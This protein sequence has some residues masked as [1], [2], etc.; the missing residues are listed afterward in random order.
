MLT[1]RGM[2]AAAAAC[3]TVMVWG[4]GTAGAAPV[5]T[6]HSGWNWALPVPQGQTLSGVAFDGSTG[7]AVGDFGTVLRSTDGGQTWA[8][9]ASGTVANLD[10]VQELDPNTVIVGGGCALRESTDGGAT[11]R[12]VPINPSDS[13]CGSNVAGIAFSS[14]T[15][16]YVE[17]QSG[18]I[19]Y[20]TDGGATVQARTPVP[21]S[22]GGEATSLTF[23][24]PTTGFATTTN[25]TIEETTDGANSWTLVATTFAGLG[26]LTFVNPQ[27]A[28]AVGGANTVMKSTD[29]GA[30]WTRQTIS[31]PSPFL[32]AFNGITCTSTTQCLM[33]MTGSNSLVLT[34]DGGTTGSLVTPSSHQLNAV[35]FTTGAGVVGVGNNG[36]IVLSQDGG[37]QFPTLI[38][39]GPGLPT[40]AHVRSPLVAGAAPGSAYLLGT[41]GQIDATTDGGA[42]WRLEQTPSNA[43]VSAGAF[44][45]TTTG[46]VI[47]DD[48]I[49]RKTIDGGASWSSLDARVNAHTQLAAPSTS[50]VLLVGPR[51]IRRSA[52]GGRTFVKV[53]GH[54]RVG[55]HRRGPLVSA[56]ALQGALDRG[57]TV[58]AWAGRDAYE[59]T[60]AGRSWQ[61]IRL[62]R[63]TT[64]TDLSFISASSGYVLDKSGDVLFTHNRGQ[65]W[66]KL[67]DLGTTAVAGISF[68][69]A[70]RGLVAIGSTGTAVAPTPIDVLATTDGGRTWGPQVIDGV[71]HGLVLATAGPDYFANL[72][73]PAWRPY[74]MVFAT[75]NGGA[76]P[77]RSRVTLSL[78]V[79]RMTAKALRKRHGRVT[80]RG[81]LT[82]VT[83]PGERVL[84]SYR[85][86]QTGAW[87]RR[88]LTVASNGRFQTTVSKLRATTDFVVYCTGDGTYGGAQGYA[89][90]TVK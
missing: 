2:L 19:L 25:G 72:G 56:L 74:N 73:V 41:G 47:T 43:G 53:A 20:T 8:G 55:R 51:G 17:L 45:S 13:V 49:L 15:T 64:I 37:A 29:G 79:K 62:P 67:A 66:R 84:F 50:T 22:G 23:T 32:N 36:T 70:Q 35:A 76:S 69:T 6:G 60:D 10:I 58:F 90:L 21:M 52:N 61:A 42:G 9:V 68:A 33:T 85:S 40:A 30:T 12:P 48:K 11:F 44:P 82:P 75:S 34:D 18:Q 71:G 4:A 54:V 27:T 80:V 3:L 57:S 59:S 39:G 1:I 83:S 88:T 24:S 16:G 63:K 5:S 89:R 26:A 31:V 65:T 81:R 46:Y 38:S 7:Y 86:R 77:Q 87:K 14:A 28:Y 78:S